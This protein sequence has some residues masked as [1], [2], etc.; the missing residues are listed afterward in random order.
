MNSFK[1]VIRI[2]LRVEAVMLDVIV[3][4]IKA[5]DVP[6]TP[7]D[8]P[9][10]AVIPVICFGTLFL[11]CILFHVRIERCDPYGA[12]HFASPF[13]SLISPSMMAQG[14]KLETYIQEVPRSYLG[15][16]TDYPDRFFVVF[17]SA[18]GKCWDSASNYTTIRHFSSLYI[19]YRTNTIIGVTGRIAAN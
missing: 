11:N 14:A 12:L 8:I 17:L 10:T 16:I 19:K 1:T 9:V 18:P 4:C 2:F 13:P 5:L 7:A 6:Q 3:C 15:W